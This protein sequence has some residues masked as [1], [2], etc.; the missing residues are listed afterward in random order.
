MILDYDKNHKSSSLVSMIFGKKTKDEEIHQ[1]LVESILE[2]EVDD[3]DKKNDLETIVNDF[4]EWKDENVDSISGSNIEE[5][6]KRKSH[7]IRLINVA[8]KNVNTFKKSYIFN[9]I[10]VDFFDSYME[11]EEALDNF[12]EAKEL[13]EDEFIYN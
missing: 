8:E 4:V 6:E 9:E 7:L 10:F 3:S 13:F 12:L 1:E 11:N 5:Y 2:I